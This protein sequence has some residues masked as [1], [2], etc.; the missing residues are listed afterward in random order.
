M[1]RS[2]GPLVSGILMFRLFVRCMHLVLRL[3]R[4]CDEFGQGC[5]SPPWGVVC[6]AGLRLMHVCHSQRYGAWFQSAA[7]SRGRGSVVVGG[8]HPVPLLDVMPNGAFPAMHTM[9]PHRGSGASRMS[10]ATRRRAL[11]TTPPLWPPPSPPLWG[12]EGGGSPL[13]LS[14][15]LSFWG[16]SWYATDAGPA[17]CRERCCAVRIS[18]SLSLSESLPDTCDQCLAG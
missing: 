4:G 8:A 10:G 11:H 5:S 17:G 15:V 14:P 7:A 18:L 13:P 3:R 2:D 16:L 12:G 6:G 9:S 1:C